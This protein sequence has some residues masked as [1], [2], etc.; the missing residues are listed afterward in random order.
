MKKKV[1]FITL[2]L[3]LGLVFIWFNIIKPCEIESDISIYIAQ[4]YG[5]SGENYHTETYDN[6]ISQYNGKKITQIINDEKL[7]RTDGSIPSDKK[8]DYKRICI[9]L[10]VKNRSIFEQEHFVA[11][12]KMS[13]HSEVL[14][15]YDSM[16]SENVKPFNTG[17]VDVMWLEMYCEDM[18]DEE[19]AEYIEGL[20]IK[21]SYGNSVTGV[22]TEN[23]KIS[24]VIEIRRRESV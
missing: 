17:N 23:I 24:D 18:T 6:L 11:S 2:I 21:V 10:K 3:T 7:V 22:K 1:I 19:I 20:T 5:I 14:Y 8:K 4:D 12:I 13:E 9:E 16:I 15:T